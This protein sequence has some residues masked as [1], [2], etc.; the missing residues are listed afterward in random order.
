MKE[1]DKIIK[2]ENVLNRDQTISPS[3]NVGL[4]VSVIVLKYSWNY[5]PPMPL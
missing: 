2:C 5:L 1:Q 3:E 4:I